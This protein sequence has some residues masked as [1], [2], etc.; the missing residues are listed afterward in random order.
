LKIPKDKGVISPRHGD[1]KVVLHVEIH[2]NIREGYTHIYSKFSLNQM[3]ICASG[4][5]HNGLTA[6][7]S[8]KN[9]YIIMDFG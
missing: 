2:L 9:W 6:F 8:Y 3:D 5:V 1:E 4:F 7:Q